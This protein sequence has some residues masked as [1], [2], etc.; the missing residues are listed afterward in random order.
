M[1]RFS[2][3]YS[4]KIPLL[5][6]R[7]ITLLIVSSLS[8]TSH[9]LFDYSYL[10]LSYAISFRVVRYGS[11]LFYSQG[12]TI[13]SK[14]LSVDTASLIT[15]NLFGYTASSIY[16]PLLEGFAKLLASWS[17]KEYNSMYLVKSSTIGRKYTHL[18]P[19]VVCPHRF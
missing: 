16:P 7:V 19:R 13:L 1:C 3:H 4:G 17:A 9:D 12:E 5:T 8:V 2:F 11:L 15:Q 18:Q 14:F 6:K 10:A